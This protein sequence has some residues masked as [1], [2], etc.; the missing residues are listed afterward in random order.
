MSK[1]PDRRGIVVIVDWDYPNQYYL[2][3]AEP[4]RTK[5]DPHLIANW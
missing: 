4:T 2:N 5:L 3:K 1:M